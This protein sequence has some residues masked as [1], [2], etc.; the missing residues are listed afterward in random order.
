MP[1]NPSYRTSRLELRPWRLTDFRAWV[2]SIEMAWPKQDKFDMPPVPVKKRT[3]AVFKHHVLK[4]RK[5]AKNDEGYV[6]NMFLRSTGEFVGWIDITTIA[7]KTHQMANFGY[8]VINRHRKKGYAAEAVKRLIRAGH[9]DL[10]F[11]RLE[12][13]TDLDNHT[14]I[15]FAQAVGFHPEGVKKHYWFQN[16]R[17][18]D[19]MVLVSTPELL[20]KRK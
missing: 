19:Q 6:F 11:Q 3:Y 4:Q 12:A 5:E 18:E 8:F 1:K 10:N 20:R 2:E 17:W 16:G 14:S 9:E 15:A 13:A 7:R